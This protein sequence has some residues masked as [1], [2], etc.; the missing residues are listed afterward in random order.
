MR[1]EVVSFL[2][3][4]ASKALVDDGGAEPVDL[5]YAGG[6]GQGEQVRNAESI[7][8]SMSPVWEARTHCKGLWAE[9]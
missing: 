2:E 9:V 8:S 3:Q 4:K 1:A 5:D 7:S 6:H